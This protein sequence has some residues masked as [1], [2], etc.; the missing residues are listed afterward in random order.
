MTIV[1]NVVIV[2]ILIISHSS[3]SVIINVWLI[4]FMIVFIS[5]V[6]FIILL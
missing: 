4:G 6:V 3:T 2:F 5:I 1:K